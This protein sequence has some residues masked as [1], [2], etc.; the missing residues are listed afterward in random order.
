MARIKV[1]RT[2]V[3]EGLENWVNSTLVDTHTFVAPGR[4]FVCTKGTMTETERRRET[5]TADDGGL[6]NL[7]AAIAFAE[8]VAPLP[9]CIHG[10]ALQDGGG[11][12]LAP[13]CKCVMGVVGR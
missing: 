7:N 5:I 1:T 8:Q 13:P 3:I 4:P 12:L 2:I 11:E 6:S 9:R 10:N